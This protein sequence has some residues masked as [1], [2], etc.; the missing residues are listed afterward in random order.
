MVKK[1]INI[2]TKRLETILEENNIKKI[3][4]LSIDVEGAEMSVIKS[5]NFDKVFIDVIGFENN[6]PDTSSVIV[7]Y[8]KNKDY[9]LC[10]F[11]GYDIF[12][13]HSKSIHLNNYNK[14]I[15]NRRRKIK[16]EMLNSSDINIKKPTRYNIAI[17]IPT[18]SNKRNF[19]SINDYI[20][21][22]LF[23][24][25]FLETVSNDHNYNFYLGYDHDDHF[26][27]NNNSEIV[28]YFND[29]TTDNFSIKL[30]SMKNL[31]GK[32]G[33]I[34]SILANEA[35]KENNYIYQ[36]GDDVRF[37]TK[38]WDNYFISKLL[39]TNNIG[40]VGPYDLRT[41]SFL[42]TQTFVHTTHLDIFK[43]YFPEEIINWDIDCWI[44]FIYGSIGDH[45]VKINNEGG[46]ERY[47]PIND[48]N[49][50]INIRN[51]DISLL[52]NYL[53]RI[54]SEKENYLL[55]ILINYH[56]KNNIYLRRLLNKIKWSAGNYFNNIEILINGDVKESKGKYITYFNDT[57]LISSFY[58][59]ELFKI[60]KDNYDIINYNCLVYNNDFIKNKQ[61][62]ENAVFLKEKK[63]NKK[64]H[65]DKIMYHKCINP[66]A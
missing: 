13:I 30:I 62:I 31:K 10:D 60:F 61:M 53:D 39:F 28:K 33:K 27:I 56:E 58:F 17:I 65:M 63:E 16:K 35:K 19:N 15:M 12:M 54:T 38:N 29:K 20:F 1:I 11:K 9:L 24:P 25:T 6:Y 5:I 41:N 37:L 14:K 32:V 47:T 59:D 48:K 49:N 44:T 57:D 36:I 42:L 21:F 46:S 40:C 64:Y 50:Y 55:T 23:L 66:Q 3:D 18:T 45:N 51:K 4:Y 8:L 22:K 34:W 43:N 2:T 26:F 7:E 52:E